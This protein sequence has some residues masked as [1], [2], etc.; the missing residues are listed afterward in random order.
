MGSAP[1]PRAWARVPPLRR[2]PEIDD[3]A[4]LHDV[5]LALEANLAVVAAGGNRAAAGQRVVADHLGT[6]E[7]A[8]DVA[9]NL[10]CREGRWCTPGNGPRAALVF[11][12]RKKRNVTEQI[13]AGSNDAIQP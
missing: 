3:V 8:R 6:N 2:K 5:L 11:A 10:A 7:P 12:Y 1:P 4:V 9:V 13:V